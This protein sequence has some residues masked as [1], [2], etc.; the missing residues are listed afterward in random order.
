MSSLDEILSG[1]VVLE[2]SIRF[3]LLLRD[4]SFI[5]GSSLKEVWLSVKLR[6]DS[7]PRPRTQAKKVLNK[8]DIAEGL[9]AKGLAANA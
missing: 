4:R 7:V 8:S 9:S 1:P 6:G 5:T 3:C 2:I